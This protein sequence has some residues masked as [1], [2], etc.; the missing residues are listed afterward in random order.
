MKKTFVYTAGSSVLTNLK[1]LR[2]KEM[3]LK[4]IN[5]T[6][7]RIK[8][9]NKNGFYDF[10]ASLSGGKRWVNIKNNNKE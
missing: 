7:K 8:D 2:K 10:G 6:I 1:T 5:K 9:S 4:K 3:F